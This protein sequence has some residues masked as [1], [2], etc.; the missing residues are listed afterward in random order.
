[1]NLSSKIEICSLPRLMGSHGVLTKTLQPSLPRPRLAGV[2][3]CEASSSALH[4]AGQVTAQRFVSICNPL[5]WFILT[6]TNLKFANNLPPPPPHSISKQKV[7]AQRVFEPMR[8]PRAVGKAFKRSPVTVF[9]PF[10]PHN[11]QIC[12]RYSSTAATTSTGTLD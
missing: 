10:R 1:M 12:F 7:L 5:P 3:F 6:K 4:L 2:V 9:A 11:L 8:Y